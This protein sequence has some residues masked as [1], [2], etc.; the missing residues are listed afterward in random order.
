MGNSSNL[1]INTLYKIYTKDKKWFGYINEIILNYNGT[2]HNNQII[3]LF[4]FKRLNCG[5]R[6]FQDV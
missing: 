4:G 5:K 1:S 2:E 6:C 3:P